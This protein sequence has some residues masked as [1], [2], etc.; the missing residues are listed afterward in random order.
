MKIYYLVIFYTF[1]GWFTWYAVG[2][3]VATTLYKTE[4]DKKAASKNASNV[5]NLQYQPIDLGQ[6]QAQAQL[7]AQ[8]NMTNS[9]AIEAQNEPGLSSTRFG[10][11]GQLS[12][13]LAGGGQVPTDVANQV[14][15]SAITGSNY[16]GLIGAAGPITAA[17][18]GTTAMNIRN[19]NQMKAM[20]LLQ[21]N[22]L[23]TGGLD[24]GSLASAAIGTNNSQNAF[25]LG[26]AGALNNVNQSSANSNG[27]MAGALGS[28]FTSLMN[29]Y[30]K[31]PSQ[32]G[33][34]GGGT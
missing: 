16:A 27:A 8:Q 28:S 24:P 1:G 17:T 2:A 31:T 5:N 10:L 34:A 26:K 23:P 19:A 15:R 11:Q 6:L 29:A 7:A 9:I 14:S 30:N 12:S 25:T 20:Q 18:L 4:E 13:D 32:A 22:P 33:Y 21:G 3:Q